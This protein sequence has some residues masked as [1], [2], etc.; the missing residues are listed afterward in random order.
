MS[1]EPRIDAYIAKAQPFARPI[2][3]KVRERVHA[4]VP[5]VEE[6]IKWSMPAYC[7]GGKI[8]I[9][10]AAFTQHAA[11]NFWRGSEL[12]LDRTEDAMGQLG[13]LTSLD[14][15]PKDFDSLIAK[16]AELAAN[17]PAPPKPKRAPKPEHAVDGQ[18]DGCRPNRDIKTEKVILTIDSDFE[19]V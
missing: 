7:R 12:G 17:V 18:D 19:F 8:V 9:G 10:T 15:L 1:R 3:E 5:D 4:V 13:R 6:A 2:L 14:D 11:V 16:A